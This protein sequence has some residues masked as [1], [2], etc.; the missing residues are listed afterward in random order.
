METVGSGF[1]KPADRTTDAGRVRSPRYPSEPL[2]TSHDDF[3][4]TPATVRLATST[5]IREGVDGDTHHR[6]VV[7][8]AAERSGT[9]LPMDLDR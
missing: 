4:D 8:S 6:T 7:T 1:R 3:L 9:W 5:R 2:V